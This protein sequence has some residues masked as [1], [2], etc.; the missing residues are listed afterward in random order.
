M[1]QC[2]HAV[3]RAVWAGM[4]GLDDDEVAW[5]DPEVE[6]LAMLD[7]LETMG[8]RA[9]ELAMRASGSSANS[10]FCRAVQ[11]IRVQHSSS[12]SVSLTVDLYA[13]IST[14]LRRAK[15]SDGLDVQHS[16][17]WTS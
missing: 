11:C 10:L 6:N 9:A 15:R 16:T 1:P 8:G 7:R 14:D 17:L 3:M 4:Q 12:M 13:L 5:G 2:A